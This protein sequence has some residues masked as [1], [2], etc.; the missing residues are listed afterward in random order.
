MEDNVYHFGAWRCKPGQQIPVS[1]RSSAYEMLSELREFDE[2]ETL[3]ISAIRTEVSRIFDQGWNQRDA[4]TW[5]RN[6]REYF[7]LPKKK[8]ASIVVMGQR[9]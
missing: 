3:P 5:E 6:E 2:L 1:K 4:D 8:L 9:D 7:Q